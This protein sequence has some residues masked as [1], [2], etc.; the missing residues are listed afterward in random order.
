[1]ISAPIIMP[2]AQLSGRDTIP[3][4]GE[5]IKDNDGGGELNYD[6]L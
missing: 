2:I 1:M 4:M 5:G 6:I 3:G